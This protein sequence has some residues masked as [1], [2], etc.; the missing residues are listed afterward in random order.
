[1]FEQ[2]KP[3][4]AAVQFARRGLRAWAKCGTADLWERVL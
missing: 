1:L 4:T 2:P 3:K